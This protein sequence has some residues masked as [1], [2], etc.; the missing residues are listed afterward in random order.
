[1]EDLTT[2]ATSPLISG[3]RY[4]AIKH[5]F[6]YTNFVTQVRLLVASAMG[7]LLSVTLHI[8]LAVDKTV[9][10]PVNN[11]FIALSVASITFCHVV[12]YLETRRHEQQLAAQQVTQE[13]REQFEN[14]KKGAKT[15]EY[16]FSSDNVVLY[17]YCHL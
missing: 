8:P 15:D 3:E 4:L 1:M 14:N 12:V 11:A 17:T 9:F 10:L 7:W 16:D 13:A 6:S 2:A 5:P